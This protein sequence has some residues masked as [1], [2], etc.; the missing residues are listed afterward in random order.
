MISNDDYIPSGKHTNNYGKSPWLMGKSTIS[1]AI[2]KKLFVCL[3]EGTYGHTTKINKQSTHVV[4]IRD[5]YNWIGGPVCPSVC[6][7]QS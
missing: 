4:K 2:K 1:M 5:N 6:W 3:P 7:F